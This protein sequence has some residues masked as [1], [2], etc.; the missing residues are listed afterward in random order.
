MGFP[1]K[2]AGP[3]S[4]RKAVFSALGAAALIGAALPAIPTAQAQ[5]GTGY[6]FDATAS[7][8]EE[9]KFTTQQLA[10]GGTL[11]FDCYR[12]PSLGVAPNGDVLASWDGRP[13]NCADAPQPNSIVGRV[14]TD[15][16]ATWGEQNDISTGITAEPKTGYSDPSIVVD[17]E[18][19]DVLNFHVKSFDAGYFNS[20]PGTDP[21]DRNVVH[22]AYATSEDNGATWVPDTVITDQVVADETWD[23]RFATSG[24]G[25]QLQYGAHKGRLVQPSVTRMTNGRVAAVAMLSDDH[26]ATWY[27]SA[28]WGNS[29]DENKIVELSDGTLMNNSRSSSGAE[30]YRK[31]SYSTDGGVTWTE[32]TLDTQLPD[33]RNNA[34]IIRAFPAAPEGSAQAKVL[35]FSNTAT[36]SGRTNGTIRMSCDDGQTWPISKVFEPGAIQYTSMATLP[37][38]DIGLLWENNGSNID[39]FYS[40]FNLS[41]LDAGCIGVDADE[42]SVTA[43]ESTTLNVTLTNPFDNAIVDRAVS[44]ALP[45]GWQAE[46]VRVSI[47]SGGSVTVPVQITAPLVADNGD[48]PVEFSILDGADRYT[49]RLNLTVQGGQEP[50]PETEPSVKVNVPNLQDTYATGDKININFAV[51]NPLGITVN[52]APSLGEGEN[53]MPANLRGF[54]P[55]QGAPN[56][57][58]RNLGANQSYNCT[59]TT[60][61]VSDSDVERGYVDIPTVWTFTNTAGETVWSKTVDVPRIELNGTQDAVTDAIVT[62][63]PINP[64]HSNGQSQTV[65]VQANVTSEGDLPAGSKVAFYL[66]SSPIDTA[67][68]D[69]EGYAS[70]SIDVDNIASDQPER[71]FE[72]RA[73][74]VVP[75]DAPRSIA[76]DALVRFTVLPELVQQ[77]SL[78]IMDHPDV[79]SGGQPKTIVVSAKATQ[80][81]GSPVAVGTP[82]TFHVNGVEHDSVPTDEEGTADLQLTLDPVHNVGEE[83]E[84][85]VEAT[86]DEL[87]ALTTFKVLADASEEP[88]PVA[89]SSNGGSFVALLA[90]LAALGGIVGAVLGLLKL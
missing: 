65:E 28:P 35:L 33:P 72:V 50:S 16:G 32:P 2:K 64:V 11:G 52:S 43:G 55:E 9:P 58:Y 78:V 46:S 51:N 6:G 3:L 68:V 81:D 10:D 57:R 83:Y 66:D 5:T 25:I 82:I 86:L 41:W 18:T 1:F 60:Y 75:E 29:M 26:G 38:G 67:A 36:T 4:R 84:V 61:E 27:P 56:C 49:G 13:N 22:V 80:L 31:V 59:T 20:Q 87:T 21:N 53:W 48:L 88:S 89:G 74:L 39:I 37:N 90:L 73:R 71:T 12:I 79:V 7:I 42:F 30:T 54:D 8:S 44:L 77:N 85:T 24:N 14:S 15:S 62:V 70:I 47:P 63:D 19:G 45:E 40:Q 69:A 23:S 76:R 34:S 17:W